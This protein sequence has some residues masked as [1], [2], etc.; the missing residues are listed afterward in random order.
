ML[1]SLTS[2]ICQSSNVYFLSK[3]AMCTFCQNL[4][5]SFLYPLSPVMI[6]SK[7]CFLMR[8]ELSFHFSNAKTWA[9]PEQHLW[10]M[11]KASWSENMRWAFRGNYVNGPLRLM[12]SQTPQWLSKTPRTRQ[13]LNKLTSWDSGL[14]EQNLYFTRLFCFDMKRSQNWEY[15]SAPYSRSSKLGKSTKSKGLLKRRWS[16]LIS[17]FSPLLVFWGSELSTWLSQSLWWLVDADF[18]VVGCPRFCNGWL[19]R[20]LRS[21]NHVK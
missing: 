16:K 3:F 20:V 15:L 10:R 4:K 18:V 21:A 19:T 13:Y 8:T 11:F 2:T 1:C 14:V 12:L 6:F 5:F 9:G 7:T 17:H